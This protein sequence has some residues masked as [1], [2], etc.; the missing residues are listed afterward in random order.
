MTILRPYQQDALDQIR[1][2]YAA[3]RRKVLLHLATGGGKCH[4]PG[5][6]ILT[7]KGPNPIAV[8]DIKP[9]ARLLGPDS[10]PRTVVAITQG[11]DHM[12]EIVPKKGASFKCNLNHQLVLWHSSHK[13]VFVMSVK[14]FLALNERSKSYFYIMRFKWDHEWRYDP[15]IDPWLAGFFLAQA[16]HDRMEFTHPAAQLRDHLSNQMKGCMDGLIIKPDTQIYDSLS[17][18]R[19]SAPK[20]DFIIARE[21]IKAKF[22][23]G[24]IDG[25]GVLKNRD[26]LL[27]FKNDYI[28][29]AIKKIA[30]SLGFQFDEM[31]NIK[32]A[33]ISGELW[34]LPIRRTDL[35]IT[36]V[37]IWDQFSQ[38][39]V[40]PLGPGDY[41]G[42]TLKQDPYFLLHDGTVSHN[43]VIFSEVLKGVHER[44]KKAIMVVRGKQLVDQ[45]SQRLFREKV[46][47]GVLMA[48]HWNRRPHENIQVC[49]IDTLRARALVPEAQL[50]VIDECFTPDMEIMTEKGFIRFDNLSGNE[51]I[52]QFDQNTKEIS[53]CTPIRH[54]KKLVENHNMITFK[55]DKKIDVTVTENHEMV[56]I[57]G[58]KVQKI[59]AKDLKQGAY[60]SIFKSG[61]AV[62]SDEIL[63]PKEKLAIA[64]QADGHDQSVGRAHFTFTKQRKI[65]MFID[66]MNEGNFEFREIKSSHPKKRRFSVGCSYKTKYIDQVFDIKSLSVSKCRAIIEYMVNWDGSRISDITYY[67]SSVIKSNADFYQIV[68]TL[69]GYSSNITTQ[70]D[71]R[72]ES[73]STAHRLFV[74]KAASTCTFQQIKREES[75][76]SGYVYCVTVPK[77]NIIVRRSGMAVAIGNCHYAA[78]PSFRWLIE[79]Y[80]PETFFLPVTATPHVP[81]GLRH[82]ADE[83]VYPITISDLIKQNYLVPPK[84][85][86]MP[87]ETDFEKLKID[88]KTG[89]FYTNQI[90]GI[91]GEAKI[92]GDIVKTWLEK[93]ENRP[94]ICFATSVANSLGM[95]D[96]FI[97]AGIPAVHIE[98]KNSWDERQKALKDL[99]TGVVKIVS[100]VGILCTGVDMPYVSCVIM[101]RPTASYN[102]MIQQLG[103]A[104]RIYPGKS[105]FIVLDHGKNVVRHGFIEMEKEC[106]LDGSGKKEKVEDLIQY[107]TC[108]QCY[109]V[110]EKPADECPQC[111]FVNPKK[112]R[113]APIHRTDID[114][115]EIK[116]V[117]ILNA[118][119]V[120]SKVKSLINRAI[121]FGYQPGWVY[122]R[123]KTEFGATHAK[124]EWDTIKSAIDAASR[125]SSSPDSIGFEST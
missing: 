54:V 92:V 112:E 99:E 88:K 125:Q 44:K 16:D 114:L 101:A 69:A 96:Q 68:A 87:S 12:F 61:I 95:V 62:G 59:K 11:I 121:N 122:H 26:I 102:L 89:D 51:L 36:P 119:R 98:A 120:K 67:Y 17:S 124:R 72:S 66:L 83:V 111:G 106:D 71:N 80:P 105:N 77:G 25:T 2:H 91:M 104:T 55:S 58:G 107:E 48:G 40:K 116:D 14:E 85:F 4:A 52:A 22:L 94:T 65:D 64:F 37:R 47:H 109:Y 23:S 19:G 97:A 79:Q 7:Y 3:G 45:A 32:Y 53:F 75:K 18:L 41:F 8:E 86:S 115:V 46:P 13:K 20:A 100:N 9:G 81:Q 29:A 21:A 123:I 90:D 76:Y 60:K 78:S 82:V 39:S 43:T 33:S 1:A 27:K 50:V 73:F 10:K 24:F 103:R 31:S 30:L 70:V 6:M 5:T 108:K 15:L 34:E 113:E 74:R 84:Y 28:K 117:E 110:Y 38:F 118:Q 63:S 42:F 93:G 35:K 56:I 57:S 49:S